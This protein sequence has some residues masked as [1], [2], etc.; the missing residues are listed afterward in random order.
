MIHIPI[1]DIKKKE[2]EKKEEETKEEKKENWFTKV[3]VIYKIAAIIILVIKYQS[4]VASGGNIQELWLWVIIALVALYFLGAEGK[5]RDT[6]VLTP[7]DAEKVL[8]NEIKR[9][10]KDVQISRW[11]KI[12]IGPN[13]GLFRYEGMPRHY[14]IELEIIDDLG[15][16]Y[17]R[18]IVDAE[19]VTKGYATIQD[20]MGKLTGREPIPV[21]TP[22][23]F[24]DLKKKYELDYDSF[25]FGKTTS[26]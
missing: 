3:P 21:R 6:G 23:I 26:K 8:K 9:K 25:L 20:S 2:E 4:I 14:Q 19:G 15:R 5:R 22:K 7:E 18:G 1:E 24:Q 16:H 10:I 12:Y 17:K 11:A 13:N